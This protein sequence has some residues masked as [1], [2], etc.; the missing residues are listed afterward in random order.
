MPKKFL[1]R[2]M[3]ANDKFMQSR[4]MQFIN[5]R[6]LNAS[7]WHLTRRS[8]S[9]A[10]LIGLFFAFVPLPMQMVL[11]AIGC[12]YARANLP[13]AIA[14]VWLTNPLTTAPVFYATYKIG[15]EIMGIPALEFNPAGDINLGALGELLDLIWR[16]VL[17]G[18][19]LVGLASGAIGYTLID[20]LWRWKTV[21]RWRK[22]RVSRIRHS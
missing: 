11:A 1:K 4:S 17:L 21:Q 2:F 10:A 20:L 6:V 7:V 3:P 19:V 14:F 9:R 22:R 15:A 8:A 5:N 12:I 18:S 16:P 13:L